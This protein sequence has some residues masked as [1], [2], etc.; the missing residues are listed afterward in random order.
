MFVEIASYDNYLSAN[1]QLSVLR[2]HN[3]ECYL[4]DELTLTIDPLLSPALGGI[5][6]MV[7]KE[8]ASEAIS[9]LRL[10]RTLYLEQ[11]QCPNCERTGLQ[12]LRETTTPVSGWDK[13]KNLILTGA[14]NEEKVSYRCIHCGTRFQQL[15]DQPR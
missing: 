5:K 14:T 2:E 9:I 3:M 11:F 12:E 4:Q 15:P 8:Q 1:M 7:L 10:N 6:L 13:L